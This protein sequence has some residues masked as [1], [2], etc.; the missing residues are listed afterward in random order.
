[1]SI[2]KDP[3]MTHEEHELLQRG[4]GLP[5]A[6]LTLNAAPLITKKHVARTSCFS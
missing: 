5:F 3:V 2:P 1:M 4:E 6:A